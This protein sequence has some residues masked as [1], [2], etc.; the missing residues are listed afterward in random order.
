MICPRCA[1]AELVGETRQCGK[2][3]YSAPVAVAVDDEAL[4]RDPLDEAARQ[5]LIELFDIQVLHRRGP[6]SIVYVARDLEVGSPVALKV[7]PRAPEAGALA[8]EAFHRAAAAA[9]GLDHRHVVPIYSAG[10]TDNLFWYSMQCVEG[11]SLAEL[12]H[13][14][15]PMDLRECGQLVEQVARA[16]DYA[17]RRGVVHADLKPANVLLDPARL[18]RL[19]DFSVPRAL[20]RLGALGGERSSTRR[21]ECLAPEERAGAEPGPPADQYA[22]ALLVY[23]CLGGTVPSVTEPPPRLADARAGIPSHAARAVERALS[24]APGGR[25]A[26]AGDFVAALQGAT[27]R[28]LATSP[29]PS[30][31]ARRSPPVLGPEAFGDALAPLPAPRRRWGIVVGLSLAVVGALATVS[32]VRSGWLSEGSIAPTRA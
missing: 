15:G 9:A 31:A 7:L 24:R 8:Q 13:E 10:T 26:S 27:P 30:P 1:M 28:S 16:L 22:L 14:R 5:E 21:I 29:A 2:C 17:H 12:L 20:E 19:T 6:A 25:F 11:Q 3:G 32:A 18:A 23:E 4:V